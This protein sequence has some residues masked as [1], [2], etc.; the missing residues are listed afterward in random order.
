[1]GCRETCSVAHDTY[2]DAAYLILVDHGQNLERALGLCES[3][4]QPA[5]GG[6]R[7]P[8]PLHVDGAHRLQQAQVGLLD[9]EV[10]LT[11]QKTGV[12]L[13]ETRGDAASGERPSRNISSV[14]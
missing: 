8:P 13:S 5:V 4:V 7:P 10:R 1:M 14:N 12:H 2:R 6:A 9:E 3:H 11:D